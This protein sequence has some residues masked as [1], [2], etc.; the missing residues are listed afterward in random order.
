MLQE[1]RS[2]GI[3]G[4]GL[5]FICVWCVAA[6]TLG[7]KKEEGSGPPEVKTD[8]VVTLTNVDMNN[9]GT[10]NKAGLQ[11]LQNESGAGTLSVIFARTR[12]TDAGMNQLTKFRNIRRVQ[13]MG[14][15][16]SQEAM[17]KLKAAVP[18]VVIVK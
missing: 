3:Y 2:S 5:I 13:A 15:P 8:A 11:K 12:L 10:I 18:E 1:Q 7:C 17:D 9:D 6:V 16:L 4:R 14:S